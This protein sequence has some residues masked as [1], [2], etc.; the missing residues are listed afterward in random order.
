M[1]RITSVAFLTAVVAGVLAGAIPAS[2][3]SPTVRPV[4]SVQQVTD[5]I[6]GTSDPREVV[7]G[8]DAVWFTAPDAQK[9]GR[10]VPGATAQEFSVAPLTSPHGLVEGSDGAMWFAASGGKIGRISNAGAVTSYSLSGMYATATPSALVAGPD[11]ALWFVLELPSRLGRIDMNGQITYTTPSEPLGLISDLALGPDD[12]LWMTSVTRNSI[13]R[14]TLAGDVDEYPLPTEAAQPLAIIRGIDGAMWFTEWAAGKLGRIDE[15]GFITEYPLGVSSR[16]RSLTTEPGGAMWVTDADNGRIGRVTPSGEY[17]WFVSGPEP[18][19]PDAITYGPGITVWFA[20]PAAHALGQVALGFPGPPTNVT[21]TP[22]DSALVVTWSAPENL[23]A[24]RISSYLAVAT[25]GGATCRT[26][27]ST[28]CRIEGLSNGTAYSVVVVARNSRGTGAPSAA[29]PLAKPRTVPGPPTK[30]KTVGRADGFTVLWRPPGSDGG[31]KISQ[32]QIQTPDGITCGDPGRALSTTCTGARA[33]RTYLI[34]IYAV[35]SSGTSTP[36]LATATAGTRPG[37]PAA[38]EVARSGDES[39]TVAWQPSAEAGS[40]PITGYQVR[41]YKYVVA[42]IDGDDLTLV[43]GNV[44]TTS[45]RSCTWTVDEAFTYDPEWEWPVYAILC[46]AARNASG[47]GQ[48]ACQDVPAPVLGATDPGAITVTRTGPTTA[49]LDWTAPEWGR[50]FSAVKIA[51]RGAGSFGSMGRWL[52]G[53][54]TTASFSGLEDGR[55]YIATLVYENTYG[56]SRSSTLQWE[57]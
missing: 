15:N 48:L 44:C 33:G 49:R 10:M 53:G 51:V 40:S 26:Y 27:T 34:R 6:S 4:G 14:V 57:Q 23:G 55:Q 3:A 45:G 43:D 38:L 1:Q 5:G 56:R 12:A 41:A 21:A 46:V 22:A 37:A 30:I 8:L 19:S 11:D 54:E 24:N 28:S 9:V 39:Y 13:L 2:T 50:P 25:P 18:S 17:R 35:N 32:Y 29:S 36:G 42:G 7:T 16:P 20:D 31:A 52:G 47:F